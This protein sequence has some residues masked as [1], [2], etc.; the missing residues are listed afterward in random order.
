[1]GYN[2][3]Y[4]YI[5]GYKWIMSRHVRDIKVFKKTCRLAIHDFMVPHMRSIHKDFFHIPGTNHSVINK[6]MQHGK[7]SSYGSSWFTF[8]NLLCKLNRI[9]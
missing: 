8:L 5:N 7:F 4:I 6:N 2:W 9:V 1:M 3:I